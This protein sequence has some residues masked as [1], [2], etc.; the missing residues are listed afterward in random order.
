MRN[1][2]SLILIVTICGLIMFLS[3]CISVEKSNDPR[4][5]V[6][7]GSL[8]CRQ[9][10]QSIYD[11]YT[12]TAHYKSTRPASDKNVLGSFH[13]G[14]NV[15]AYDEH[16]KMM[17]E[18][19]DSGMFQA[20]YVNGKEKE[21]HRF[22]LTFGLRHAQTFLYWEGNKSFEL[23]VS[24]FI[25]AASWVASPGFSA[26][27]VNF[28]RFIGRTCYE[29]HSSFIDSK[30]NQSPQGIEE[31]L[32][33]TT[34]IN[35]IDCERCHGPAVNHVNFHL[36][37]PGAKEA[38]Y[39]IKSASL[40]RQQKLDAC[41][42]C[43]SGNDKQKE[44]SAF[45]FKMGDTLANFFLPWAPHRKTTEFDVHGNQYQLLSES[46]CFLQSKVMTCGTCHDP[47]TNVVTDLSMYSNKC[48]SCHNE[49]EHRSLKMDAAMKNT[50]KTNCI[51]CHMPEQP[52]RIFAFQLSGST[53]KAAYLL[54]THKIAVYPVIKQ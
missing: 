51:D 30:L 19:R 9:C 37:Y 1:K 41:A 20:L 11:T 33:K 52:S 34:L 16:T 6:Y 3:R 12:S 32:D 17:M 28:K 13:N 39:I 4:G 29:C 44:I 25:P 18:H 54:R 49:V 53:E 14:Q 35:G 45:K 15:F 43:H 8:T 24:Y 5:N 27:H 2:K 31:V 21:A 10:H 50:I 46:K 47:H 48:V 23:P 38:K 7:A 36:A 40:T 22:D 42:V 26:T